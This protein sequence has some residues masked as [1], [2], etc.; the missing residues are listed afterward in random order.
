MR[1]EEVLT[2][3]QPGLCANGVQHPFCAHDRLPPGPSQVAQLGHGELV[4]NDVRDTG[5]LVILD[6]A[7]VREHQ[8]GELGLRW[9]RAAVDEHA[10]ARQRIRRF[11]DSKHGQCACGVALLVQLGDL[12]NHVRLVAAVMVAPDGCGRGAP[13]QRAQSVALGRGSTLTSAPVPISALVLASARCGLGR[14]AVCRAPCRE[15][16]RRPLRRAARHVRRRRRRRNERGAGCGCQA[17][18]AK[19]MFR[20]APLVH[21]QRGVGRVY[22]PH[23]PLA[24][25]RLRSVCTRKPR[26][27]PLFSGAWPTSL[28]KNTVPH[29][30][31]LMV[32]APHC[33]RAA[34]AHGA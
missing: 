11:I 29:T 24:A 16:Q 15:L 18:A 8:I 23:P 9:R 20:G 26:C 33:A 5:C 30:Q 10:N 1:H 21:A 4:R 6:G 7:S 25:S 31:F 14:A 22:P 13:G 27:A 34:P 28:Q 3:R 19:L 17:R 2:H 12:A 32:G